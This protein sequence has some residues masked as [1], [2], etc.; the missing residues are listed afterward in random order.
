MAAIP[1]TSSPDDLSVPSYHYH[2]R[3]VPVAYVASAKA[4][5]NII[6]DEGGVVFDSTC[7]LASAVTAAV[8]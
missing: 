7:T 8:R 3:T 2:P 1:K 6:A 5:I 4:A